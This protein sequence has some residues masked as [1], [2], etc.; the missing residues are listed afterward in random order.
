MN[1]I[2]KRAIELWKNIPA[3]QIGRMPHTYAIREKLHSEFLNESRARIGNCAMQAI[4][5]IK[6]KSK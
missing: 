5:M 2:T 4:R 3:D 1:Q 6:A